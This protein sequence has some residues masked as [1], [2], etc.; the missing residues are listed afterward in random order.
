MTI[1]E[2]FDVPAHATGCHRDRAKRRKSRRVVRSGA[3]RSQTSCRQF[4]MRFGLNPPIE[5]ASVDASSGRSR[6]PRGGQHMD[7]NLHSWWYDSGR[8]VRLGRLLV[9]CARVPLPPDTLPAGRRRVFGVSTVL[10]R[11]PPRQ[12]DIDVDGDHPKRVAERPAALGRESA[13]EPTSCAPGG[14]GSTVLDD[15]DRR[16]CRDAAGKRR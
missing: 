11:E 8:G 14:A 10:S 7:S 1:H 16:V 4:K 2:Y 3:I 13:H 6:R 9:N 12:T 15:A 5:R